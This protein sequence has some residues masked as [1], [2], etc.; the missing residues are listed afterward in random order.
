M[1]S[2]LENRIFETLEYSNGNLYWKDTD[3]VSPKVR[4]KH[5]GTRISTGYLSIQLSYQLLLVHRVVFFMHNHYWP[6]QIDHINRIRDDNRI[7]N[8]RGCTGSQ[9]MY[10]SYRPDNSKYGKNVYYVADRNKYR[11]MIKVNKKDKT[12]GYYDDL[13][14]AQLVA[15]EAR[16][17]Y[18]GEFA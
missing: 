7:E 8:L 3:K 18:Y 16:E 4:G 1:T 10:N 12:I 17:K 9:N 11:V 5:A 14:L 15:S 2:E 13:E 6:D